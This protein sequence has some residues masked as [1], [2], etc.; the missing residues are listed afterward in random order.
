MV[1]ATGIKIWNV[2]LIDILKFFGV[3]FVIGPMT[4]GGLELDA[5]RFKFIE[6]YMPPTL[7]AC[8]I[9]SFIIGMV[10][11]ILGVPMFKYLEGH[12]SKQVQ[13]KNRDI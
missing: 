9:F 8:V 2:L 10:F 12:F 7:F 13:Q 3:G 4:Y 5:H 6:T 1:K 11:V